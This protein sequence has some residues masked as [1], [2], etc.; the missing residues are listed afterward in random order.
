M[1][2]GEHR[3]GGPRRVLDVRAAEALQQDLLHRQPDLGRVPVARQVDQRRPEPAG[4]VLPQEQPRLP[5]LDQVQH[6]QRDGQQ[7][8]G[9]DLEQLVARIG[10]QDVEQ[11]LAGVAVGR[12]PGARDHLGDAAPHEGDV[13]DARRVRRRGEQPHE[14]ELAGDPAVGGGQVHRDEVEPGAAVHGGAGVGLGDLHQVMRGGAGRLGHAGHR[15]GHVGVAAQDAEPGAVDG[16]GRDLPA[17]RHQVDLAGAE[18]DEVALGQPAQQRGGLGGVV[19]RIGVRRGGGGG[20]FVEAGGQLEHAG[21]QPFGVLVDRPDVVEHGAQA[22]DQVRGGLVVQGPV[23][24]DGHPGLGEGVGTAADG[25]RAVAEGLDLPAQ[26]PADDDDRMHD[27]REGDAL[28]HD[29]RGDRV[30]EVGHVVGDQADHRPAVGEAL[31]VDGGRAGR[32]HR[33]ELQVAEREAGE[34]GR[35]VP[36]HLGRG[37]AP[38]V[39]LQQGGEVVGPAAGG[40]PAWCRAPTGPPRRRGRAVDASR[41]GRPP[42]RPARSGSRPRSRRPA[43]APGSPGRHRWWWPCPSTLLLPETAVTA[44]RRALPTRGSGRR[45]ARGQRSSSW[46]DAQPTRARIS[47]PMR[48]VPK[49]STVSRSL[50]S[51][52]QAEQRRVDDQQEQARA[53]APRTAA[54]AAA[55]P[56]PTIAFTTP[57]SRPI[58]R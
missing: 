33:G 43:C 32:A 51:G 4:R 57:K 48:A 54:T 42:G 35:L 45:A 39:A 22:G 26:V 46:S 17:A 20:Q 28:P 7:L 13:D 56:G 52:G 5:A 3:L 55:G 24:D 16:A 50:I 10:L 18:E 6:R 15:R 38:V 27:V 25:E 47:P 30:D 9:A 21:A 29:L 49:P 37:L 19:G 53:S 14:A 34:L 58:Q 12:H 36:Q 41:C 8:V 44:T 1:Q 23:D 31:H 2:A 40:E 11:F